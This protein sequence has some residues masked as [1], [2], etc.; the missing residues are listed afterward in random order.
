MN[1]KNLIKKLISKYQGP[2]LNEAILDQFYESASNIFKGYNRSNK[3][4]PEYLRGVEKQDPNI[5]PEVI[6]QGSYLD[7]RLK[8]EFS[9]ESQTSKFLNLSKIDSTEDLMNVF[10]GSSELFGLFMKRFNT[11]ILNMTVF[12]F[13]SNNEVA[14]NNSVEQ[15]N[16][17]INSW[18]NTI[19]DEFTEKFGNDYSNVDSNTIAQELV[20]IT[21]D[22]KS[23][24]YRKFVSLHF[25]KLIEL[26]QNKIIRV[27]KKG[28]YEPKISS[29][30]RTGWTNNEFISSFDELGDF[31]K[32]LVETRKV[33]DLDGKETGQTLNW[34]R[35][36]FSVSKLYHYVD[37]TNNYYLDE[38]IADVINSKKQNKLTG[39]IVKESKIFDDI[40]VDEWNTLN[41]LYIHFFNKDNEG[42]KSKDGNLFHSFY[43]RSN[44]SYKDSS[45]RNSNIIDYY[46]MVKYNFEKQLTN[47]YSQVVYDYDQKTF[48]QEDLN[49]IRTNKQRSMYVSGLNMYK[50]LFGY[51]NLAEQIRKI[52]PYFEVDITTIKEGYI[53]KYKGVEL[54]N[55]SK[56]STFNLNSIVTDDDFNNLN[57][58]I[59]YVISVNP[60]VVPTDIVKYDL[61]KSTNKRIKSNDVVLNTY[62]KT[63]LPIL[64]R[65]LSIVGNKDL[66]MYSESETSESSSYK[67]ALTEYSKWLDVMS[68]DNIKA[69]TLTAEG[70]FVPSF[71]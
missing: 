19:N 56:L 34:S 22:D 31:V 50:D 67:M 66:Q 3:I 15:L 71:G 20:D 40:N 51:E 48:I 69:V 70:T 45:S 49:T 42:F 68:G 54:L 25:K 8:S 53:I 62:T 47:K 39:K 36:F 43:V 17:N 7:S 37:R 61:E 38:V 11:D 59:N 28:G 5:A 4:T 13:N 27:G 29:S 10:N 60:T 33:I 18:I 44:N 30:L 24:L 14:F 55:T 21:K 12:G 57:K 23:G 2:D 52:S 32:E 58:L 9:K 1:L 63:L 6:V 26:S 64:N 46:D 35:I 16:N 41:S 65:V